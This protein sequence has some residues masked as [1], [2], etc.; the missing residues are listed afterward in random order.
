MTFEPETRVPAVDVA[1]CLALL[2]VPTVV[3]GGIAALGSGDDLVGGLFVGGVFGAILVSYRRTLYAVRTDDGIERRRRS[4]SGDWMVRVAE[5]DFA[6]KHEWLVVLVCAGIGIAS[7]AS[8]V[9]VD[10]GRLPMKLVL[11]GS[12]GLPAALYAAIVRSVRR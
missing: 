10:H 1:E 6:S 12:L 5:S 9:F 4:H 2:L 8:L 7:L 3:V 11:F